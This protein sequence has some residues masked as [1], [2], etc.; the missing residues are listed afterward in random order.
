V[1]DRFSWDY[2]V[3]RLETVLCEVTGR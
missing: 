1:E 2:G 3:R